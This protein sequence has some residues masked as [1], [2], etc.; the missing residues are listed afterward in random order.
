MAYSILVVDDSETARAVI[1]RTL[2][3]A[4]LP[5]RTMHV[6]SNGAEAL[7]IMHREWIDLLFTDLSMPVMTGVELIS[8]MQEDALLS[9]IPVVVVSTD[10]SKTRMDALMSKGVQAYL[11]KPFTPEQ[12]KETIDALLKGN[13]HDE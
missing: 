10:G 12:V 1:A 5:I 2:E 4:P 8:R 6:A 9:T 11:R 7:R 13:D 3:M